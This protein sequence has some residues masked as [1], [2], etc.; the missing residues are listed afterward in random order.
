[1][2]RTSLIAAAV[3]AASFGAHA[4]LVDQDVVSPPGVFFGSGNTNGG[5][6][7]D[8]ADGV[9]LALRGKLRHDPMGSPQNQWNSNGDSTYSF[10]AGSAFGQ[11]ASTAIWS[12]EWSINTNAS[13]ATGKT[14]DDYTY[15]LGLDSDASQGTNYA[16]FDLIN[17]VNPG[18]GAVCWDHA[19][20]TNAAASPAVNCGA[21]G[22]A[23]TYTGLLASNNAA[24]NS[25]KPHWF[26]AGFDPTVDGTYNIFLSAKDMAG[27]EVTRTDIQIIVGQGGAA[28]VPEPASLALVGVALAGLAVSRRRKQA[29]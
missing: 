8:T 19:T 6:T 12:F 18:N 24:Q 11:S 16:M 15:V 9:E 21:L 26:I 10:A 25:W 27:A 28:V 1:M 29:K 2:I 13:G 20:G 5:F 3:A 17:D 7:T 22:A 14:L 4:D 23:A